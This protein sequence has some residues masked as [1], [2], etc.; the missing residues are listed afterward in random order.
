MSLMKCNPPIG[1]EDYQPRTWVS[2]EIPLFSSCRLAVIANKKGQR[3][4]E[5]AYGV[6]LDHPPAFDPDNTAVGNMQE[7][8]HEAKGHSCFVVA[9]DLAAIIS[10]GPMMHAQLAGVA[11]HEASHV[12]DEIFEHVGEHHPGTETRAYLLQWVVESIC[13]FYYLR[14]EC[15]RQ[16]H[17]PDEGKPA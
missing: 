3:K 15:L 10:A 2:Y 16:Y 8:V 9:I 17:G 6:K 13:E 11:G 1:K 12:V 14:F 4:L 5:K 7:L